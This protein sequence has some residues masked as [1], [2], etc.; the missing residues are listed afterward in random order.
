MTTTLLAAPRATAPEAAGRY[1]PA[2]LLTLVEIAS[3]LGRDLST[4]K[5]WNAKGQGRWPN[6]TQ[7]EG[8]RRAWRVPVADLV[9]SGDL[10]ASQLVHVENELAVRREARETQ[11]LRE[12]LVRLE[13]QLAAAVSIAEERAATIA[14]LSSLLRTGGAA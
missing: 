11:V 2:A 13:E 10:D 9:A 14:L 8:G 12:Q 6:A 1:A 4:V 3:L 7:D 5:D